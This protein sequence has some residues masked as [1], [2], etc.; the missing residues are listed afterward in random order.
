MRSDP[1]AVAA[2]T[3][4]PDSRALAMRGLEPVLE[5][6]ALR[7]GPVGAGEH[8][9]LGLAHGA[10]RFVAVPDTLDARA[11]TGPADWRVLA[12]LVPADAAVWGGARSLLAWHARHRFCSVCGSAT[13]VC[14]AGWARACPACGAEHFPRVDPVVIMLA[15]HRES[16]SVLLGRQP[17]FPP[18]RYSALAGFV[19][20][21]EALEEAVRREVAEESGVPVTDVTYLASQPWPFPSSLMIACLARATDRAITLDER[22]LED[23]RWFTRVE[24]AAAMAGDADAAF[25]APPPFAVARTLL[26]AWLGR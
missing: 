14:K 17:R 8:L 10:A 21:G 5:D 2:L 9:L 11:L 7:W 18:R 13:G 6:G 19:E 23:A 24:V 15:A 20:P 25:I 26:A 3:A 22:E 4:H 1:A 16:D 12:G